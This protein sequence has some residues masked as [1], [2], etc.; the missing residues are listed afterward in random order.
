LPKRAFHSGD[1][2]KVYPRREKLFWAASGEK[3]ASPG[4]LLDSIFLA[5]RAYF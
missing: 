3:I 1:D 2:L 5:L 4:H